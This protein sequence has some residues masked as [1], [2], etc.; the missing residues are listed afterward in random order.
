MQALRLYR[1]ALLAGLAQSLGIPAW[2]TFGA[3]IGLISA[4]G[5]EKDLVETHHNR[6]G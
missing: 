5:V 2:A 4:S 1:D 6:L 3:F